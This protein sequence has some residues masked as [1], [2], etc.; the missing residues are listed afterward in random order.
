MMRAHKLQIDFVLCLQ[1][2]VRRETLAFLMNSVHN[3]YDFLKSTHIFLSNDCYGLPT[4]S[5]DSRG[6][7]IEAQCGVR[8]KRNRRERE[9]SVVTKIVHKE[10]FLSEGSIR[11]SE[12]VWT[13]PIKILFEIS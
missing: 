10:G 7:K 5:V 6:L 12:K 1:K 9:G 13:I 11:L 3:Q 2:Y 8:S 4:L